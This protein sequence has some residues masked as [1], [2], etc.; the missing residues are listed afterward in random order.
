MNSAVK[1]RYL[2]L[3]EGILD[4]TSLLYTDLA[5]SSRSRLN[6]FHFMKKPAQTNASRR[7]VAKRALLLLVVFL[8]AAGVSWPQGANWVIDRV[9][10][11]AKTTF[12]HKEFPLVLG[13]DLQGGTRL[14]YVADL[15]KIPEAEKATAMEG[16]RDV[17]ERR[18]NAL[19]VSEPTVQTT[20][21][22]NEWRISVELAGIRDVNEAIRVIGETPTLDFREENADAGRALT[23]EEFKQLADRNADVMKK[24]EAALGKIKGGASFKDVAREE[25][26]ITVSKENGGELGWLLSVPE[27][28][29]LLDQLRG[30]KVGVQDK[31]LDDGA[32]AYVADVEEQRDGGMEVRASHLV[33][34]WDT[35]QGSSS[36]STKEEARVQIEKI[37]Q[38][39]TSENFDEMA[40]KYSQEA[41]ADK[42]AGDLDWFGAGA[43]VKPFEDAV[44]A[45]KKGEVSG[46]V[47]T[48]FGYHL[49]KKTDERSRQDMRVR[50]VAYKKIQAVDIVN[51]E[52]WKRTQL[53]GKQLKRSQL[54][55]DQNTGQAQVSLQFDDEGAKLFAELTKKNI[56]K[57]IGIF[58]D[59]QP[60]SVPVV[61]QEITGGQAVI[62]GSFTIE[63]GKLLAQRLQAG[64]LPV[65]ISIIAQQT[66]GAT[67][68][69]DSVQKSVTA[70]LIGFALVALFAVLL[71]RIPGVAAVLVL[72]LY[73]VINL[74]LYRLVPIT[75]TLSGIAG[76]I[77]SI[78]MAIDSNVLVFERLKEEL[79]AGKNLREALEDAFKRAWTSIR[80][81]HVTIL[82]SSIVLF[83]F[84]SSMIKGFAF[85]LGLGTLISLFTATVATRTVLRLLVASPLVKWPWLFLSRRNKA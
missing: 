82:I 71:Y 20:K 17:I 67:L 29:G 21:N 70:G 5:R 12:S 63:E 19:G 57:A 62:S 18:V 79:A 9:N 75:L 6:S 55:F 36:T 42:T 76:F 22:G 1:D 77:L 65:P 7:T 24:A 14:E 59:D 52:P 60:I 80:D 73:A 26:E 28:R 35:A 53:T 39:V 3:N 46:I 8:L 48:A 41:G 74:A 10:D 25:S 31:V 85:T 83:G 51:T 78:G 32:Y 13:L 68:G 2:S 15:S 40:K 47:E 34:Q 69:A 84:S 38:E 43:M 33:I 30:A 37:K 23:E 64:A 45:M 27:Y 11:V 72:V 54:E 81:G 61:N 56:G 4:K 16:V 50:V 44:F 66:V 49:I 58:L